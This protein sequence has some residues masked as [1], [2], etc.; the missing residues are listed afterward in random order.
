MGK[1]TIS[2]AIFHFYVSSPEGK[3]QNFA[4]QIQL[5]GPSPGPPQP[6][7]WIDGMPMLHHQIP[8]GNLPISIDQRQRLLSPVWNHLQAFFEVIS[9]HFNLNF[10]MLALK[11]LA[12]GK[13]LHNYGKIHHFSW[14]NSL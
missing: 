10:P 8:V 1:S 7:R 2:M 6:H 11:Y 13:R 5:D 3:H 12:S 4:G 14:D 9:S